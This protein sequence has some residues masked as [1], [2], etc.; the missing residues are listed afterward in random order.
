MGEDAVLGGEKVTLEFRYD[1]VIMV[2]EAKKSAFHA[3]LIQYLTKART[4]GEI[5]SAKGTVQPTEVPEQIEI[6]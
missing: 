3:K 2:T 6:T 1:L 5:V 4:D